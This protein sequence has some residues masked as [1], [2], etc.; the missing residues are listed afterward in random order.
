MREPWNDCNADV[1]PFYYP[2]EAAIR[3]CGLTKHESQILKDM[4]DSP[5]PQPYPQW[6]CL[7]QRTE[8]IL[9]AMEMGDIPVGR[10]GT[11]TVKGDHV[12]KHRRTVRHTDLKA[13]MEKHNP[14]QKPDF[15]FDEVERQAHS[16][17]TLEA[18]QTLETERDALKTRHDALSKRFKT[19]REEKEAIEGERDSLKSIVGKMSEPGLR[20]ETTYQNIIGALLNCITGKIPSSR[21][22][23]SF[24]TET[25]VIEA[26][27]LTYPKHPGLS[28][29][30]LQGKF[31]E[32]KK[33]LESSV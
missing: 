9:D 32:A 18:Y 4:G 11:P 7:R 30:T 25:E 21:P 10:D 20:A 33:S 28:Q 12:A 6:P 16:A 5:L 29:R 19:L 8:L 17:L 22:H 24:P 3:W 13:W 27:L 23:P 14:G 2:V 1:K 31:A 15:L 26:I